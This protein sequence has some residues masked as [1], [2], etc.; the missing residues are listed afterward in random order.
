MK[1]PGRTGPL[2]KTP[3]RAGRWVPNER[4]RLLGLDLGRKSFGRG[5]DWLP[6]KLMQSLLQLEVVG[7][8]ELDPRRRRSRRFEVRFVRHRGFVVALDCRRRQGNAD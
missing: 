1:T 2:T 8:A 3:G 6:F 5:D 4:R 7:R